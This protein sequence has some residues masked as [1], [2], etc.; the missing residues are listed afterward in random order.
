[1]NA[2]IRRC[3]QKEFQDQNSF[4]ALSTLF[5]EAQIAKETSSSSEFKDG[6]FGAC[7]GILLFVGVGFVRVMEKAE[8]RGILKF[9]FPGLESSEINVWE[10]MEKQ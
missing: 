2:Y 10:V 5:C 4:F 9:Y 1:M 7:N 3:R 6:F 8:G